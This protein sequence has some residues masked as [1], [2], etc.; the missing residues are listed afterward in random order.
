MHPYAV[1]S[2]SPQFLLC[3]SLLQ[4]ALICCDWAPPAM[5]H[6][7]LLSR[8]TP[9][10]MVLGHVAVLAGCTVLGVRPGYV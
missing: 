1:T 3:L 4:E 7:G 6:P 5:P 8:T 10:V 2:M 9:F